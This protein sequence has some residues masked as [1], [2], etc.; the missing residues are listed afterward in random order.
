MMF[1]LILITMLV[2][3]TLAA[4]NN[5]Q[6][7]NSYDNRPAHHHRRPHRH[8]IV[9]LD[10]MI[11]KKPTYRFLGRNF[12]GRALANQQGSQKYLTMKGKE[13]RDINGTIAI[14][15]QGLYVDVNES[16]DGHFVVENQKKQIVGRV[17]AHSNSNKHLTAHKMRN[18]DRLINGYNIGNSELNVE[19]D[20][21][22]RYP[23]RY[24]Q[25]AG[26]KKHLRMRVTQNHDT[27]GHIQITNA[28]PE[29]QVQYRYRRQADTPVEAPC[30]EN[31]CLN[32]VE[33]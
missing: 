31:G 12:I 29:P 16:K 21:A 14:N 11:L 2:G 7:Y 9:A 22:P 15:K 10:Q 3:L 17:D 19:Q 28:Q 1:R 18:G 20:I 6:R 24:G 30:S 8:Q 27:Q 4:Y 5:D 25:P 23:A 26:P 32:A 13:E 33:I